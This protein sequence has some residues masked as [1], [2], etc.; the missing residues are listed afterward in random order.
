MRFALPIAF[1]FGLVLKVLHLPYH[2]IFLLLVL[3]TGLVWVVLPL[4][5]SSDKVAA[6]TALAVWGWAA[7]S[8][9]LFKL[10]PFRTFTLVLAFAFTTVGTYLVL[11]NRAWGSRSFQVLTGVFILVMLAMAQA[12]SARFHFTNLAF[13]IERD[14]DFRSWDKYSFFLAREGDIQ[15]S[16]AANSTA[17]EAAMIAHD[18]HAAEQ[19]R[20]R[21]AD[22][23]SGT[24]E[25]FSPLDHDHR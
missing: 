5:R 8:I 22:I 19:L 10:F 2:T 21:R 23:G 25:A 15:G 6:W 7:H 4:I 16:L 11:K 18:E 12:T 14:T 24:W 13:S 9:A 20:A 3:A 17:L 1:L